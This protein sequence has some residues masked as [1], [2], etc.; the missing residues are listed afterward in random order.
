[1][2]ERDDKMRSYYYSAMHSMKTESWNGVEYVKH[3]D[4]KMVFTR[5]PDRPGSDG[6]IGIYATKS[7]HMNSEDKE[8]R[9]S[10]GAIA[11]IAAGSLC[12]MLVFCVLA[13]LCLRPRPKPY[14]DG[15]P[16]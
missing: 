6:K 3:G 13:Y 11:G 15:A 2:M 12:L 4:K 7:I 5:P 8:G 16:Q 1:M 10:G 9:L 14:Y